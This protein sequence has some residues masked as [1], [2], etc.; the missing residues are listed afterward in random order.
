LVRYD[1]IYATTAEC[2]NRNFSLTGVEV[3]SSTLSGVRKIVDAI[4][5]FN[6]RSTDVMEKYFCRVDITEEFP[7][8]VSKMQPYYS[9]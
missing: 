7:F 4:F 6:N 9:R 2:Y 8:L 3:K 1:A 5:T